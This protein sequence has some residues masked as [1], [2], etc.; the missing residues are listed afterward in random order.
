M[1]IIM[2]SLMC[3]FLAG[4]ATSQQTQ[5]LNIAVNKCPTLKQYTKEQMI[6]AAGEIRNLPSSS[7]INAFITDYSKLRDACRVAENK[8]K[9]ALRRG[10]IKRQQQQYY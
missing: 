3:L 4:C 2:I 5:T 7:Q 8:F 6:V 9:A 10:M 1:K